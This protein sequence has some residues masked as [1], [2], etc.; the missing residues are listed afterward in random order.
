[1]VD[2]R[3][4]VGVHGYRLVSATFASRPSPSCT[5]TQQAASVDGCTD[6]AT[7]SYTVS[8]SGGCG[9]Y[10]GIGAFSTTVTRDSPSRIVVHGI[11]DDAGS[12]AS[13]SRLVSAT[14]ASRPSPSCAIT[15]QAASVDGCT[16]SATISYTVSASGGCGPYT[17]TGA[18]STTVTRDSPSRIVV[19]GIVDDAGSTASCSRLV[20]ATFASR[21]SPSCAITQQAASAGGCTDSATISYTVSASGGCGP[22]TGIGAFSTTVT[23]DSP[24]RIV[25]HGIVDDA[26]STASCS[27]LVSAT[28]ASRP[29]PSCAITQQ[30]ASAGGCTDSATISYTVSASGGCGPYTGTG[31]FSTTVTRDS[32][33]RI[34]VH[35]IVDDAGT[36]ASCLL[37]VSATF[38]SRPDAVSCSLSGNTISGTAGD[39]LTPSAEVTTTGG[40]PPIDGG[41]GTV[42]A[43]SVQSDTAR[44]TFVALSH[45]V[46]DSLGQTS[47][48]TAT[49]T[50]IWL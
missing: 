48:C 12:T 19:H 23:R 30:A 31:A 10:T 38:A 1:M 6:S 21:P 8:A 42:E 46:T 7:I 24:S 26:G 37:L 18:F 39:T 27:R 3:T 2:E 44:I 35:G 32:P 40:C 36:S 49:S 29:S 9:P 47:T 50:L 11:V 13:C 4:S 20:S 14:F 5:I 17:G 41:T 34:V 16:D 28:F 22:Y 25:V 45:T 15:Q 43:D 33:S